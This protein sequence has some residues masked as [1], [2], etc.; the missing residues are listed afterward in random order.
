LKNKNDDDELKLRK[1][2]HDRHEDID[3]EDDEGTIDKKD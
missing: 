1:G 3:E 2:R